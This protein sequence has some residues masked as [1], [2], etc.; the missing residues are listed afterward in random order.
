MAGGSIVI[1]VH[2]CNL[3]V[4]SLQWTW[5]F[6]MPCTII[7]LNCFAILAGVARAL[8][9]GSALKLGKTCTLE[10]LFRD[11]FAATRCKA[12]F[13][14]LIPYSGNS[15]FYHAS[16]QYNSRKRMWFWASAGQL[17]GQVF[18]SVW[19]LLHMYPFVKVSQLL[20]VRRVILVF[21]SSSIGK[22]RWYHTSNYYVC[23]LT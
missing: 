3:L 4:S 22:S 11:L 2:V 19:V 17:V 6:F 21:S 7:I 16:Y 18:F 1:S 13:C 20:G 23:N 15:L 12:R 9:E 14:F 5:L 10:H 8:G